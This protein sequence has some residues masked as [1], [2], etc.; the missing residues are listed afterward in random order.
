MLGLVGYSRGLVMPKNPKMQAHPF[1]AGM[2]SD[3]HFPNF[4]VDKV[5]AVL[6]DLCLRIEAETP[7][8]ASEVLALTQAATEQI[9]DLQQAFADADSE[10]E[11][12]A[13]DSIGADF[14]VI[15][16]AYG[17]SSIDVEEATANR[18]W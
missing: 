13:R 12:G 3:T 17:W 2:Y 10:I 11:T 9:N 4:L 18:E 5:K 6:V 7:K 14:E 15:L 1:V 8:P 16:E